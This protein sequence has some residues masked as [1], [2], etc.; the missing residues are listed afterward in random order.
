MGPGP[1]VSVLQEAAVG[2]STLQLAGIGEC[3]L[4]DAQPCSSSREDWVMER[5]VWGLATFSREAQNSGPLASSQPEQVG[6]A[7]FRA[8]GACGRAQGREAGG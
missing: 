8:G 2:H 1:G 7:P 6:R 4:G 5:S 3:H